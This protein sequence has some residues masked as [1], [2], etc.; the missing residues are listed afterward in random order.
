[1]GNPFGLAGEKGQPSFS[2]GVVSAIGRSLTPPAAAR[3]SDRYYGNLIET[4]ASINPGNSGGPLFNIYGRVIGVCTAIKSAS[5]VTEG[6]GYAIPMTERTREVLDMLAS[7]QPIR[8]GYL[9]VEIASLK[10]D[11]A[12]RL[13]VPR[14]NG[15]IIVS[16]KDPHGAAARAGLKQDDIITAFDGVQLD[17]HDHLIRLVGMT[18][19]GRAVDVVYY[20]QRRRHTTKVTLAERAATVAARVRSTGAHLGVRHINWRGALLVEP[21]ETFL[22]ARGVP[23]D[24]AGIYV[25]E[26]SPATELHRAGQRQG[27]VI[28]RCNGKRV[29][30]LAE[31]VQADRTEKTRCKLELSDET[32]IMVA[33]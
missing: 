10:P 11:E 13:G 32:I 21:T 7:G 25:A 30:T 2:V 12:R 18:P 4:D 19:V 33:K 23:A 28:V 31:F 26:A 16:L 1:V 8:Y 15:A 6:L 24:K 17:D 27:A 5:G 22:T 14:G 29:R 20:R 9:G 3:G